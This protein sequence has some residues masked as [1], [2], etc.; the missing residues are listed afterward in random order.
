MSE[1]CPISLKTAQQFVNEHHRHNSSPQGHK[2]SIGLMEGERLIGV[3]IVGR[4]IARKQDD[5]Y[6]AEITRCCVLDNQRNAS[7]KLYGAAIRAAKAMGYR[8]VITYTLPE[9]SGAS[10]KAVGFTLDGLTAANAKGWNMPGRP[11]KTP[12]KYP[13]SSKNRWIKRLYEKSVNV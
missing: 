6:T 10:L 13:I 12:E 3:V 7:S 1:L 5:G 9:E 4:P 8:R 2:F 11:R